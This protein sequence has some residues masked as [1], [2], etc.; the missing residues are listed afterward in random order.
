VHR[1]LIG[2]VAQELA[3]RLLIVQCRFDCFPFRITNNTCQQDK[4][5]SS[6]IE[7]ILKKQKLISEK[8]QPFGPQNRFANPEVEYTFWWVTRTP[9]EVL[10][11]L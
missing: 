10:F 7:E 9:Q 1:S 5:G 8:Q 6:D 4:V 3:C 11:V 2:N